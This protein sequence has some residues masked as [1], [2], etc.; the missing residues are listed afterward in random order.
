MPLNT[1]L[2]VQ[3]RT[4]LGGGKGRV[5]PGEPELLCPH[6]PPSLFLPELL[7]EMLWG[8]RAGAN[9][10]WCH[11][12]WGKTG[13]SESECRVDIPNVFSHVFVVC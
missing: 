5:S 9:V 8:W 4:D 12:M 1:L 11:L 13:P 2:R 10:C 7:G 6:C 3:S